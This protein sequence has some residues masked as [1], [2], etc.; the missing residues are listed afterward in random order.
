MNFYK[1]HIGDYIKDA[2]HLT[3]LEH[4]VY[5]RLMDVYYTREAGIPEDKAA[6]LIGA[7]GKDELA[8]LE[9]VLDEFFQ[10]VDGVWIQGRCERE[11]EAAS[12]K[13]EKN[14]EN[15]KKGGRPKKNITEIESEENPDGSDVGN[16][17][18]SENN[19]SQTPD[20]RHQTPD[21]TN[22]VS[23]TSN[24]VGIGEV[25][26]A[27]SSPGEISKAMRAAGVPSQPHD[28]RIL[29]LAE[30]GVSA[31]T[32]S[33]A[34]ADARESRPNESIGVGYIVAII[35]RWAK[36]ASSIAAAGAQAPIDKPAKPKSED[37]SWKRS[38]A[39]IE[40]KGREVGLFPRGGESYRDY[41][42]R[43]EAELEKRKT[44]GKA[45]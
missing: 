20:S 29:K 39:G 30:Q 36:D 13:G 34:C 8:A 16:H 21:K 15:G 44:V 45:A 12:A 25:A 5:A 18:G 7:R 9:N 2:G 11:I 32:V 6:R 41:A 27:A 10:L 19:L 17:V 14:R 40:Q 22:T 43:I 23:D 33:A 37:W 4:G 42:A 28:P 1:R 26:V 24:G 3:L 38:D 35:N 31:A